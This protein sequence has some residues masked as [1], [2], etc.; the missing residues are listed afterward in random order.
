MP[1]KHFYFKKYH[2]DEMA[3]ELS[4]TYGIGTSY[5]FTE[6][7]TFPKPFAP[8]DSARRQVLN[9]IFFLM[10][11]AF[12]ISYYKAF[13]PEKIVVES[14][15]LTKDEAAFFDKLYLHGLGEFAVKNQVKINV[16]FP[17]DTRAKTKAVHIPLAKKLLVPVGGGKDS[18]VAL[19]L[20]R[21]VDMPM[22][23]VFAG[24]PPPPVIKTAKKA[25][26]PFINI[27]RQIDPVLLDLV[28]AGKVYNGHVPIVGLFSFLLWACG[29]LYDYAYVAIANERSANVGSVEWHG[30]M[31]NH[32]YS[33]SFEFERDFRTLTDRLTPD[34]KYFSILRPLSEA[35]IAKLFARKCSKYVDVFSSCNKVYIKFLAGQGWVGNWCGDCDKCR[36]VFLILAPFMDRDEL[37]KA[38]GS[39]P[40]NDLK[41]V[42]GFEELM[43]LSGHKPFECVGEVEESRWAFVQLM[44]RP[45][46][47]KDKVISA[48]KGKVQEAN[49]GDLFKPSTEHLIPEEF[50]GVIRQF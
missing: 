17:C 44:K 21:A 40:L 29:I 2:F 41:Q 3:G 1:R 36:F 39:N 46:W 42:K 28:K 13:L 34:F 14:G 30:I 27:K 15:S 6:K 49:E 12:G 16:K 9:H 26:V 4:L 50:H 18:S 32:Q 5:A 19:E 43:G 48:L 20:L 33:K 35:H 38:V 47:K 23:A 8:L 25:D 7:V 31:A 10:H 22:T 45:E 24:N 11:V 37:I